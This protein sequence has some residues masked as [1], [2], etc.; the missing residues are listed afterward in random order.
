LAPFFA[1]LLEL[2]GHDVVPTLAPATTAEQVTQS[3]DGVHM[4]GRP[5]HAS[6]FHATL[7]D[8]LMGTFNRT[9]TNRIAAPSKVGI[10]NHVEPSLE[11]EPGII[12]HSRLFIPLGF[13]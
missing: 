12:D 7:D 4:L 11:V 1:L 5:A 13:G 3:Q 2:E 6:L 9:G 10:I 8:L